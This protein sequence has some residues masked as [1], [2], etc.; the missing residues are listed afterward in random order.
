MR[1]IE[2]WMSPWNL[3]VTVSCPCQVTESWG[4]RRVCRIA[5]GEYWVRHA[6]PSAWNSYPTEQILMKFDIWE[7]FENLSRKLKFHL[8]RTTITGTLHE[9][10]CAFMVISRSVLLRMRNVSD[11]S[12]A[13]SRNTY[14]MFS[15]F[16]FPEN[17][18]V[19]E[20]MWKNV[21]HSD[22][23]QMGNRIRRMRFA[24]WITKATNTHSQYVILIAFP[25]QQWSHKHASILPVH[26]TLSCLNC[27][28]FSLTAE[29]WDGQ[30]W[31]G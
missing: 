8:N 4:S 30:F 27:S 12:C 7:F 26:L 22:R 18:A 21:V 29:E 11:K 28:V 24:C 2:G 17:H 13:E 5:K 19:Y 31:S 14:F 10:R 6:P 3:K 20:I 9:D 15:N 23:P 1:L 25:L 16:F